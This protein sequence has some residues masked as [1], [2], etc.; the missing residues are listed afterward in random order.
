MGHFKAE[1]Y[2][3]ISAVYSVVMDFSCKDRHENCAAWSKE[4]Q[5]TKASSYMKLMCPESCGL[6]QGTD[7][8][9]EEGGS[10]CVDHYVYPSDCEA[11]AKQGLCEANK[12]WMYY[13]C[14]KSCGRCSNSKGTAPLDG[15]IKQAGQ[16]PASD[17]KD[18]YGETN[19]R[20]LA[21]RQLCT[22]HP[23]WMRQNCPATCGFCQSNDLPATNAPNSRPQNEP[24][25][26]TCQVGDPANGCPRYSSQCRSLAI[27]R[28]CPNVC[29]NCG[30]CADAMRNC[31]TLKKYGYC[32]TYPASTIPQ[33]RKTCGACV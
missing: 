2:L 32:A 18:T 3:A 23:S 8:S 28:R 13:N 30:P 19:C 31:E 27:Y 9:A 1:L 29:K 7:N 12:L 24:V 11:W 10:E 6:C 25:S 21:A 16:S 17:C 22:S 26:D 15:A 14:A 4:G 5:C 20:R 33:C